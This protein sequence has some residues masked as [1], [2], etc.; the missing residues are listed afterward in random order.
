[1]QSNKK[2]IVFFYKKKHTIAGSLLM[3]L[4]LAKYIAENHKDYEVYYINYYNEHIN[5]ILKDSNIIF[6]DYG[7]ELDENLENA[8]YLVPLVYEYTSL[9]YKSSLTVL[10]VPFLAKTTGIS[11][12]S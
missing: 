12:N 5:G 2:K 6:K 10:D 1:M 4:D 7:E 8:I 9:V 11:F 3:F